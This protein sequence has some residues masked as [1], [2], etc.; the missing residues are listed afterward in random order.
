MIPYWPRLKHFLRHEQWL[1][2][3]K[4]VDDNHGFQEPEQYIADLKAAI[5][6]TE[7]QIEKMTGPEYSPPNNCCPSC[8]WGGKLHEI[9]GKL[10]RQRYYLK[11][12]ECKALGLKPQKVKIVTRRSNR[13]C[14]ACGGLGRTTRWSVGRCTCGEPNCPGRGRCHSCQGTGRMMETVEIV[15]RPWPKEFA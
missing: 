2:C 4:I 14:P 13:D 8:V 12:L 1:R 7:D 6:R 9:E 15:I 11:V 10:E 5:K 3:I